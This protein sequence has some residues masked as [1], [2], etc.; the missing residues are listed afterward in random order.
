MFPLSSAQVK[1]KQK[2]NQIIQHIPK[3]KP[4]HFYWHFITL[5]NT[6]NLW[7]PGSLYRDYKDFLLGLSNRI[8]GRG[9]QL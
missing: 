1:N 7:Q 5:E 8:K 4:K 3:K 2:S 6:D 9:D